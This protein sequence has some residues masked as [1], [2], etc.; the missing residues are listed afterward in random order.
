MFIISWIFIFLK[1]TNLSNFSFYFF[2]IIFHFTSLS[3]ISLLSYFFVEK[4]FQW[5][6]HI[7]N[8]WPFIMD[9]INFKFNFKTWNIFDI[10]Y[11]NIKKKKNLKNQKKQKK[12]KIMTLMLTLV[13]STRFCNVNK[14]WL[15]F[16]AKNLCTSE[17]VWFK[18]K[19]TPKD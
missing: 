1:I 6:L 8:D 10:I 16:Y 14:I 3:W 19:K 13:D 9:F 18:K 7:F 4:I 15:R 11:N 12:V 2:I 17:K 5:Y